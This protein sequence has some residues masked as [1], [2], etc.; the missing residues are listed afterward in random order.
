MADLSPELGRKSDNNL[1]VMIEIR[2]NS[3]KRV[4]FKNKV[5]S[6]INYTF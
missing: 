4:E 6:I 2:R 5:S 1:K 3:L